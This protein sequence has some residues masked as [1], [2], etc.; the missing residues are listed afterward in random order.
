MNWAYSTN[1]YAMTVEMCILG[2]RASGFSYAGLQKG[3]DPIKT[4]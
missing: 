2:C 1:N 3:Y 4:V